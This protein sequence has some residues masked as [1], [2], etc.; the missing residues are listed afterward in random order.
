MHAGWGWSSSFHLLQSSVF[1]TTFKSSSL[2][3]NL[4]LPPFQHSMLSRSGCNPLI[5][6]SNPTAS[7]CVQ[8]AGTSDSSSPPFHDGSMLAGAGEFQRHQ[9]VAPKPSL[10]L[11]K[12]G[13]L[14]TC[15]IS[16]HVKGCCSQWDS[17]LYQRLQQ[18]V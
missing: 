16:G 13:L 14:L 3:A 11:S 6:R 15:H 9:H 5:N 10:S 4:N 8:L 2:Q 18:E 1:S 7:P 17:G 12:V